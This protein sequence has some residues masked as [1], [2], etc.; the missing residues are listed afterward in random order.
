MVQSLTLSSFPYLENMFL[1]KAFAASNLIAAIFLSVV[2]ASGQT[3]IPNFNRGSDYDV[4]HYILRVSFHRA[5]KKVLGDT[6]VQLKPTKE[7]LRDVVLDSVGMNY[8]SVTL[9]PGGAMLKYKTGGDK[10]TVNLDRA[11]SPSENVSIRFQY[12]ATPK[13]GIYFVPEERLP[14]NT[15]VHSAQIWTQGEPDE[16]RHWFP[17]FDFPSDKATTEQFITAEKGE[18]VI[19]NGDLVSRKKIPKVPLRIISECRCPIPLTLF[20][21]SLA[22]M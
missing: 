6:T 2:S 17:S 5:E 3:A 11:Y 8:T 4:Q 9:E 10:I 12:T 14:D 1:K 13:K 18:T 7:G 16:A 19:G 20:P 22:S 21:S 15:K